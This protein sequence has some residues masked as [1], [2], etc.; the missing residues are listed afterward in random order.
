MRN[1]VLNSALPTAPDDD[2][3]AMFLG[4][5]DALTPWHLKI[6][7]F[8]EDPNEWARRRGITFPSRMMGGMATTLE[9]AM[10][11]LK[12][13]REF[14]DLLV[15][16]LNSRGLLLTDQLHTTVT[17]QGMRASLTT[18]YGSQ[19]IAFITSPIPEIESQQ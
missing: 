14:Y 12:G 8:F 17:E 1:A 13:R 19:F 7:S 9:D 6:L 4:Y 3:K 16:D 2:L 10:P 18:G 15:K 11:E 5:I